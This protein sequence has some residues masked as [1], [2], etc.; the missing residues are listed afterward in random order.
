MWSTYWS[1]L[2]KTAVWLSATHIK[3]AE[4]AFRQHMG[5]RFGCEYVRQIGPHFGNVCARKSEG[6]K[7]WVPRTRLFFTTDHNCG[8]MHQSTSIYSLEMKHTHTNWNDKAFQLVMRLNSNGLIVHTFAWTNVHTW[9]LTRARVHFTIRAFHYIIPCLDRSHTPARL[10]T[11]TIARSMARHSRVW[12]D[13]RYTRAIVGIHSRS[14]FECACSKCAQTSVCT[15]HCNRAAAVAEGG[16]STLTGPRKD[17]GGEQ[18]RV[19]CS[20]F[21][22]AHIVSYSRWADEQRRCA[23]VHRSMVCKVNVC[24]LISHARVRWASFCYVIAGKFVRRSWN[25]HNSLGYFIVWMGTKIIHKVIVR[26]TY[27]RWSL[28]IELYMM[29]WVRY[30]FVWYAFDFSAYRTCRTCRLTTSRALLWM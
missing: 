2:H 10:V 6:K 5:D 17:N 11:A 4:H 30:T 21:V 29:S 26:I 16:R 27:E 23:D 19:V 13:R 1:R 22:H 24:S 28:L 3:Y 15:R 20:L 18:H 25:I 9:T 12:S 14:A 8:V 7:K